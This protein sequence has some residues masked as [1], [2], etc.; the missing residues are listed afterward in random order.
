M[1]N[2]KVLCARSFYM[3]SFQ[4]SSYQI[5]VSQLPCNAV[6]SAHLKTVFIA[7]PDGTLY[8]P[9]TSFHGAC[10]DT[11]AQKTV[12]GI[13]QA[14]AYCHMISIPFYPR[15]SPHSFRFGSDVQRSLGSI[16]IRIPTANGAFLSVQV[17]VVDIDIPFLLGLEFL[18]KEF[19]YADTVDDILVCKSG[20]WQVPLAHKFGHIYH[21]WS[22]TPILY[23]KSELIRLH[24]HFFHPSAPKMID[25]IRRAKPEEADEA[26]RK[27]LAEI[28]RLCKAC[29]LLNHKPHRFRVSMP[30]ECNS[31]KSL[32]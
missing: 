27:T 7:V 23:T 4:T 6:I 10:I 8:R 1:A 9:R 12:I 30:K 13:H 24:K 20:K 26:T 21:D 5:T 25:L 3:P 18:T 19:L 31:M 2:E 15:R 32:L 29:Q 28:S 17:A 16:P 11:G 14:I 22:E